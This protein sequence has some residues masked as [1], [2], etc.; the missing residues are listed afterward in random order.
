MLPALIFC[1]VRARLFG[2]FIVG[3]ALLPARARGEGSLAGT[4]TVTRGGVPVEARYSLLFVKGYVAASSEGP[5]RLGQAGRSFDPPVLA[6]VKGQRVEFA[7]DE[8]AGIWHHV[9]SLSEAQ[10][11][12]LG[13]Y[14]S[15]ERRKQ[16]FYREGRVDVFCDIHKE[17]FATLWVLPNP[18]YVLLPVGPRGGAAFKI[19][20]VRV[21]TFTL[22]AWNRLGTQP[23][24]I[25]VTVREG[26][27][28]HVN[29]TLELG[30]RP[31]EAL[32]SN[33][34]DARG[35]DYSP[36]NRK[37]ETGDW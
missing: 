16:A 18:G 28:T 15:P 4:L 32:I 3:M 9:F 24:E 34:R 17:M 5:K 36:A 8:V 31:L 14:K 35:R 7:N 37:Q 25:P 20:N 26:E 23:L 10:K 30:E 22:V 33:H 11:F 29:V 12:D 27:T 13:R 1:A 19:E 2:L 6:L 21:G